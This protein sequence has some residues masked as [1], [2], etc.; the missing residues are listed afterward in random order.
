MRQ[1]ADG[2]IKYEMLRRADV[3]HWLASGLFDLID[4][5]AQREV[6]DKFAK[7]A[8]KEAY[9]MPSILSKK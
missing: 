6:S 7:E 3:N 4:A 5:K 9:L 2:P 8:E 1:K